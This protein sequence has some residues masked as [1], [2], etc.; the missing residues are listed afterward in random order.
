MRFGASFK[1]PAQVILMVISN[2]FNSKT[3]VDQVVTFCIAEVLRLR[4]FLVAALV[5][6]VIG[7]SII[8]PKS[9]K[10]IGNTS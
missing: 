8:K 9:S 10:R 6:F 5:Y 1:K 3:I 4:G 7:F 2:S